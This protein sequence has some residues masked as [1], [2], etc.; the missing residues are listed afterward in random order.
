MLILPVLES[1]ML[2]GFVG[3]LLLYII[4]I[5][6]RW[7]L[8]IAWF[9]LKYFELIVNLFASIDGVTGGLDVSGKW[10]LLLAVYSLLFILILLLYSNDEESYYFRNKNME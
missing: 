3:L 1:T 5:L 6:G 4:P 10:Y 2:I 7:M 8:L 9:Q